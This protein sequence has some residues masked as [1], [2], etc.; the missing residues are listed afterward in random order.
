MGELVKFSLKRRF[1][2]T[3]TILL[4]VMLCLVLGAAFF[5]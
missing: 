5:R 2:N 3:A 1:V 4:N